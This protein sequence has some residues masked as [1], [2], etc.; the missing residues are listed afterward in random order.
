[1]GGVGAPALRIGSSP[2]FGYKQAVLVVLGALSLAGGLALQRSW[3]AARL[4]GPAIALLAGAAGLTFRQV[5]ALRPFNSDNLASLS[6]PTI[7]P[8]EL[9]THSFANLP[10]YR[11]LPTLSIWF[12]HLLLGINPP[13]Y[14][15]VNVLLWVA[16]AGLV[17]VL[18]VRLTGSR[19]IA[20]CTALLLLLDRR[21]NPVLQVIVDRGTTIAILFGLWAVLVAMGAESRRLGPGRLAL[22]FG[23]LLLASLGKEYGMAFAVVVALNALVVRPAGWRW[24]VGVAVAAVTA[25]LGLHAL[26]VGGSNVPY[27]ETLGFYRQLRQACYVQLGPNYDILLEGAA[28]I[29]QHL[30]NIAA[31]AAGTVFPSMFNPEGAYQWPNVGW[32]RNSPTGDEI[33]TWLGFGLLSLSLIGLAGA[34]RR[35]F[36]FVGLVLANAVLALMLYRIRNQLIGVVGLYILAGLGIATV[37]GWLPRQRVGGRLGT[38]AVAGVAVLAVVQGVRREDEISMHVTTQSVY[39]GNLCRK[40]LVGETKGGT[41][42]ELEAVREL[43]HWYGF[44]DPDCARGYGR[45]AKPERLDEHGD[46]VGTR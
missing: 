17:Y 44:P 19:A 39:P 38:V 31:T 41:F 24:L 23:L 15:L 1:L 12:Q 5:L 34:P 16:C 21:A 32:A 22:L 26:I 33:D 45:N 6:F 46:P 40:V 3:T 28:R 20:A 37:V 25:R 2:E 35:A 13:S 30:W 14:F 11:P 9:A 18:M 27:C 10:A 36:P 8:L 7:G 43:R 42:I 29:H 4:H